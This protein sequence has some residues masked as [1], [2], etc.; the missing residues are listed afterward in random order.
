[1][2]VFYLKKNPPPPGGGGGGIRGASCGAVFEPTC[3]SLLLETVHLKK[4]QI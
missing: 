3:R 4:A 1:L 2:G